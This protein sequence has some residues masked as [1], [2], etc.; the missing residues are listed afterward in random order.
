MT[1]KLTALVILLSSNTL[2]A[3]NGVYSASSSTSAPTQSLPSAAQSAACPIEM[4]ASQSL[5]NHN[6][7]VQKGLGNQKFG[8]RISLTLKDVHSAR[9]TAATVRVHGLNGT[10]RMVPTPADAAHRWTAV[11][12]LTV[13][14]VEMPDRTVS[15]D[16]WIGGF[17]SV[18]SIELIN[19]RYS[20][21]STWT[22][23]GSNICRIQPDPIMLITE[24]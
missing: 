7:A 6:I 12:T 19:L 2:A 1:P 14:F 11:K 18:G 9:V 8:Q 5:W 22:I 3:Q 10:N 24:R 13:N 21:G 17:T 15:A 20:D 23:S 16:L 4:H